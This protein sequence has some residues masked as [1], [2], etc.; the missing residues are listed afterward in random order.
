MTVAR[1]ELDFWTSS[2]GR[3][4]LLT[5]FVL[6]GDIEVLREVE[7]AGRLRIVDPPYQL[8]PGIRAVHVGGHTPGQL[9]VEIDSIGGPLVLASDT[10]HFYEEMDRDRPFSLFTD[11]EEVYRSLETLRA[12]QADAVDVI[13]GHDPLVAEM[14]PEVAPDCFDLTTSIS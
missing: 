4:E 1:R 5:Q 3:R 9:I 7:R 2:Y 12:F 10:I 13:A 6:D 11:L 14:Y 8:A